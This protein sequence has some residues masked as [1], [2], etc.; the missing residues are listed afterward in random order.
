MPSNTAVL[1]ALAVCLGVG[2]RGSTK[3]TKTV[4]LPLTYEFGTASY[5]AN[6]SLG[7]PAQHVSLLFDTGSSDIWTYAPNTK[8]NVE[9]ASGGTYDV[10]RSTQARRL[11]KDFDIHYGNPE[12]RG[13]FVA[14]DFTVGGVTIKDTTFVHATKVVDRAGLAVMGVGFDTAQ[15][16]YWGNGGRVKPY[17]SLLDQMVDQGRIGSR[18]FSLLLGKQDAANGSVLFGGYDTSRFD[19]PM[20]VVPLLPEPEEPSQMRHMRALLTTLSITD[21][22]GKRTLIPFQSSG[23][24]A[25]FNSGNPSSQLP[26]PIMSALATSLG[27]H[28]NPN[29]Q[30][31]VVPCGLNKTLDFGFGRPNAAPAVSV[32]YSDM[33]V[34]ASDSYTGEPAVNAD[35]SPV[36]ELVFDEGEGVTVDLGVLGFLQSAYLVHHLDEKVL[37][38]AQASDDYSRPAGVVEIRPGDRMWRRAGS[39]RSLRAARSAGDGFG[40]GRAWNWLGAGCAVWELEGSGDLC[41]RPCSYSDR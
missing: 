21:A 38:I 3:A 16:K 22:N 12:V 6:V 20:T 1:A 37:G 26:K 7:S 14:D 25:R 34:Y 41:G 29:T 2:A 5:V 36:C 24:S 11:S 40:P 35:G 17:R 23:V 13:D 9:G 39:S 33:T 30:H 10:S 32:R 15:A 18:S 31:Y 8:T 19:G 28:Y 27:A 4:T